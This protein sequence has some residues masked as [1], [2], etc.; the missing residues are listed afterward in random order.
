M[1]GVVAPTKIILFQNSK[2]FVERQAISY[3]IIGFRKKY[4]FSHFFLKHPS[5]RIY[6]FF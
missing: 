3:A 4:C 2:T 1:F 6:S 5:V